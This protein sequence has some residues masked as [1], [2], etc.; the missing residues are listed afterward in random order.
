MLKYLLPFIT[1]FVLTVSLVAVLKFIAKKIS[2][3][4]RSSS[5]HIH[6][7]ES[8]RIGGIAMIIAFN[9]AIWFNQDLF[10]TVQ[11]YGVMAAS[12]V[13][14]AVGVW[15]DL[16]EV[17]WKTQLFYQVAVAILVFILGLRIYDVTNP[18]TGGVLHFDAGSFGIIL[19][20]F[21]VVVWIVVMINAMNW[22]DGIDGLSGGISFICAIT[23]FVL[24][25]QPE[26]NQ[27]PVA[28]LAMILSGAILGFVFFNFHPSLVLAGTSGS[29][30]MGFAL[31]ALAI[32]AGTK[33]ATAILALSLP[34]IDFVWVIGERIRNKKSVFMAD[35]NHLHHKLLELGWSQRKITLHFYGV[36]ALIAIVALNTRAIGKSITLAVTSAIMVSA[37]IFINKKLAHKKQTD[38]KNNGSGRPAGIGGGVGD[39][40][41]I[42]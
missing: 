24:S 26:V 29:M 23:I 14:L 2:W 27:P 11:L 4:A 25:L 31:A 34:I 9:L 8:Y 41:D 5:R 37:I 7:G 19:S 17:F 36:T 21:L 22:L 12:L 15:D 35:K 33:I 3:T 38:E 18:L 20:I 30:F 39:F 28:I 1:A 6:Q 32:F 13:V 42:S 10:I 16:R 40:L